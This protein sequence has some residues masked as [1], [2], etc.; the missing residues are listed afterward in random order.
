M[1]VT[2]VPVTIGGKN[3]LIIGMKKLP[4]IIT[5]DATNAEP[6]IPATPC[7]KPIAMETPTKVK[8]VPITQGSLIPTGPTPLH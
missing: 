5:S 2:T 7:S 3:F 4:I 8:L 1:R 6:K